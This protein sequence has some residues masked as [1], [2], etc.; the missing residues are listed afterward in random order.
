MVMELRRN[1]RRHGGAMHGFSSSNDDDNFLWHA[2]ERLDLHADDVINQRHDGRDHSAMSQ[3]RHCA[4]AD[5][6]YAAIYLREWRTNSQGLAHLNNNQRSCRLQ[7]FR[8]WTGVPR[9]CQALPGW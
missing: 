9:A 8:R 2:H 4:D 3:W 5:G 1:Q 7:Q 6:C